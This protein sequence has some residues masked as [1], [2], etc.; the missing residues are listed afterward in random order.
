M[1]KF[2]G[3]IIWKQQQTTG[4]L[5]SAN[6]IC[7]AQIKQHKYVEEQYGGYNT[8]TMEDYFVVDRSNMV[9]L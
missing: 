1:K 9:E 8:E 6:N 5:I 2:I 3:L 7:E 4:M